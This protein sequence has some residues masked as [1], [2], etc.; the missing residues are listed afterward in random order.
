MV[1]LFSVLPY[2]F[3]PSSSHRLRHHTLIYQRTFFR[4]G[5]MNN[6]ETAGHFSMAVLPASHLICGWWFVA[7]RVLHR[8]KFLLKWKTQETKQTKGIR[9]IESFIRSDVFYLY[10]LK[11]DYLDEHFLKA[12]IL[13]KMSVTCNKKSFTNN[14]FFTCL[15]S[16]LHTVVVFLF[17]N[18]NQVIIQEFLEHMFQK[19][20]GMI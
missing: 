16:K 6:H 17:I 9:Q 13:I 7:S 15:W 20:I 5:V 14:L 8:Y 12:S 19:A 2:C 11:P 18:R 10:V 4:W 3:L 1:H